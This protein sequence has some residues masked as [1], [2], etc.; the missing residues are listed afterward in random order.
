MQSNQDHR[1]AI[2]ESLLK[3]AR[4]RNIDVQPDSLANREIRRRAQ[5]D[6]NTLSDYMLVLADKIA[7][8]DAAA[9]MGKE[10]VFL[11]DGHVWT[12]GQTE[13]GKL[14]AGSDPLS[15]P[16][17]GLMRRIHWAYA[18]DA[19]MQ[20]HGPLPATVCECLVFGGISIRSPARR[21]N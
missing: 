3:K 20:V 17:A 14:Q 16:I 19:Q 10:V 6:Y 9:E 4:S 2:L 8:L 5:R 1:K 13:E 7:A 12:V 18:G 11:G 21:T 15:R